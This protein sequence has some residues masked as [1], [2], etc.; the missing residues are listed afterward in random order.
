MKNFDILRNKLEAF[1]RRYYLNELLKG[2]IFFVGIGLLYLLAVLLIEHF[3][4]LQPFWRSVLF[5]GVVLV[6]TLLFLK[7]IL[8]PLL[9]LFRLSKGLDYTGASRIIG[10][11]FPEVSD[12]LLN[13]LQLKNSSRQSELLLA[14]ID[15]KADEL[16]PVPFSLAVDFRKNLPHL[17]YTGIPVIII[18]ILFFSGNSHVFTESY[19][20][21]VHYKVAYEP[22][23]PFSFAVLNSSL[24]VLENE[25][26]T[27]K[28]RTVGEMVPDNASVHYDG[29]TYFL[30]QTSPGNFEF[31]FESVKEPVTFYFSGNDV[32]SQPY[33]IEVVKVPRMT[34]FKMQLNYPFY[35]GLKTEI[36]DGTGNVVVPEG[37]SVTWK[38]KTAATTEVG[39]NFPDT[40]NHFSRAGNDFSFE[41]QIFEGIHYE[42][43]TSNEDVRDFEKL[44]YSIDVVKDAYPELVL[45]HKKDSLDPEVAYFFGK[46]SDDY[47]ITRT[48]LVIHPS[49]APEDVVVRRIPVSKGTYGEFLMSFPDT[50]ALKPGT[51]Y[52]YYFEA[53]D[54]DALH[55][56]KKVRSETFSFRKKTQDEVEAGKL[57]Q[58]KEALEGLEKSM[59]DKKMSGKELQDLERLQREQTELSYSDRKK[60]ENFLQRQKQ[61]NE[62][63]KSYSEKL[64]KSLEEQEN[65]G[66]DPKKEKLEER[67]ER[68]EEKLEVSLLTFL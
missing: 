31:T 17:R 42:I 34:D 54:N 59:E 56:Y 11:H 12:K 44:S 8:Y 26:L 16:R 35:T 15:Q 62:L 50:I 24:E 32:T 36:R 55:N 68:N 49:D 20:R 60:L 58:Q 64:K 27:L 18:L 7:F 22:P 40:V 28:V 66:S 2:I 3:L 47:G 19:D 4:W 65:S 13:L 39:I 63:M 67:L 45:E 52:E 6:E 53:F 61:Q 30:N 1:I 21:V 5:W 33:R 14:G 25:D 9:K 41:K 48:Q 10:E 51:S 37:T 29:Q 23:A 57:K 46:V 38:L 43:T